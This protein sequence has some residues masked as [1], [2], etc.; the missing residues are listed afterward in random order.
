MSKAAPRIGIGT[1]QANPTVEAEFRQLLPA[2]VQFV[3]TRL[4]SPSP[5]VRARLVNYIENLGA[6]L[7]TFGGMSLDVCC[8]ACTGSSYLVG[9]D[10]EQRALAGVAEFG[11]PVLTAT[12]AIESRL[13][14]LGAV[15]IAMV[16]PYPPW[17]LDSARAYW[18]GR[19]FTVR[20]LARVATRSSEDTTTIYELTSAD[21]LAALRAL[22]TAGADA[23]VFSGTGMPSADILAEVSRLTGRPALCSNSAMVDE[24]LRLLGRLPA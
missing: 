22:D 20:H 24:S 19:G 12:A 3:T 11:Y 13:R 10:G 4:T 6:S 5:S 16:A 8:F 1:P 17:L 9:Y 23:I 2:D 14:Q 18:T 21:A 7:E 15:N